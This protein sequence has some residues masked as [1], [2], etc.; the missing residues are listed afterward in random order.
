MGTFAPLALAHWSS[1][2]GRWPP[3]PL[4]ASTGGP[5]YVPLDTPGCSTSL[6]SS[7]THKRGPGCIAHPASASARDFPRFPVSVGNNNLTWQAQGAG[8]VLQYSAQD[9]MA[10]SEPVFGQRKAFD[11]F[12]NQSTCILRCPIS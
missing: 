6:P 5:V 3:N 7:A 1:A 4:P 10:R 2:W 12:S 9:E 11:F 8:T